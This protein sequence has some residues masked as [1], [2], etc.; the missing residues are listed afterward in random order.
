M[1]HNTL[2][3]LW[4][5]LSLVPIST[6]VDLTYHVEE[7]K[8][9]GSFLGD[10]ASDS[11]LLHNVHLEDHHLI[12]FSQLL[13][14]T[15]KSS[16]LFNVSKTGKLFTARKLDAESL[17]MYNTECFRIV[18]VAVK[19]AET[20]MK[21]LKIKVIL[22]DINDHKPQFQKKQITIEF[23]EDD[24]KGARRSLPNAVDKDVGL[25]NSQ[26]TYQLKK[27]KDEPFTLTVSKNL[28]GTSELSINLGE[29]LN[30][31]VKDIYSLQVIAKDGGYPTKQSILGVKISVTD[32]ND[33][34]P[35]F[36]QNI[37]NVSIKNELHQEAPIVVLSAKDMD[38][39]E[40]ANITYHF[41][42]KTSDIAKDHFKLNKQT[43]DIFLQKIFALGQTLVHKLFVRATDGGRP[44]LSSIAMVVVN[45]VNQQNNA[46]NIDVNFVSALTENRVA[47][48]ED[49]KIGSF[50]AYV[51][52]T[53]NDIGENGEVTCDLKH[54]TFQLLSLGSKEYKV[55]VKQAVD[56]EKED[57]YDITISCQDKG[58]P[59]L[60]TESKFSIQVL[61]VN[62]LRP[63][64]S[65]QTFKFLTYENQKPNFPIGFINA[66]DQDTGVGGELTYSL[67]E[68]NKNYL[69]FKITK[70][71][72]ISTTRTL[73][74]EQK[75]IYKF[76]VLVKDNGIP[77]LNN[78]ANV[79]VE[80]MDENDNAPYFVFPN[81]NPFS[82]DI[83]Y[84]PQSKNNI[85]VLKASD[86]DSRMNAF[87][88]YE[89]VGG[90]DKLMF[91]VN[92]YT[93]HLSFSR[94]IYQTDAGTYRLK[95]AVK[96][97]GTPTLSATTTLSLKVILSNNTSEMLTATYKQTDGMI[98]LNL[99]IVIVVVAVIL[100]VAL[101]IFITACVVRYNNLKNTSHG[102]KLNHMNKF[103]REKRNLISETSN[104]IVTLR[105]PDDIRSSQMFRS[106][107]QLYPD[108]ESQNDWDSSSSR[109]LPATTQMCIQR[110][111][112]TDSILEDST[113]M[114]PSLRRETLSSHTDFGHGWSEGDSGE[115][116]EIPDSC[117]PLVNKPR[118]NLQPITVI[119]P[120]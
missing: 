111:A 48:S 24:S 26:I 119:K 33:N 106:R 47:I 70:N 6:C 114:I 102:A 27:K 61:D 12:T 117:T 87:L 43:G 54:K 15:T 69:P 22:E 46:P 103:C 118:S 7:E 40:N 97:N 107:S 14:S 5:L 39:G 84:H 78:T 71:G 77:S 93:G 42:L 74:C 108:V 112:T 45:V 9:E 30:R 41:T 65:K 38:I 66:T 76:K 59:P 94:P 52:V 23:S 60:K 90:D 36:S 17:C 101:V 92:P 21:I 49:I 109:T 73:D 57:N 18:K 67:L 99:A 83:F 58:T 44:P 55:I 53:D 19:R 85:T 72:F 11:H 100:S 16:G 32:V 34:V 13:R 98:N 35:I 105:S 68:S 10:I 115:Y 81:I 116:E 79:I 51:M 28:D 63:Q 86:R 88:R 37:Y 3:T 56:R 31:E 2:V 20:F 91:K 75:E 95:V 64:F 62:D 120:L 110:I 29:R 8:S 82:L 1:S 96:D 4:T 50:I 25:L 89:I 113:L 80:V 104:S